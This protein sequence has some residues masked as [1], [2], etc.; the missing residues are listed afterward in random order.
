MGK[1]RPVAASFGFSAVA[2]LA[3]VVLTIGGSPAVGVVAHSSAYK[4]THVFATG[5]SNNWSGYDQG[6]L[7]GKGPFTS[8]S[9]TWVVPT[10]KYYAAGGGSSQSSASW[11]GLGGGCVETS[12]TITDPSSL[13]QAGTEQDVTSTGVASYYAWW[14]VVPVPQIE[15]TTVAIHPG[16]TVTVHIGYKVPEV[17]T[18]TLNDVTD[19]QSFSQAIPYPDSMLTAEWIEE[20]PV[21]VSAGGSSGIGALP[22]LGVVSFSGSADNGSGAGLTAAEG[23][24]LTNATSG[25]VEAT[26]SA[27]SSGGTAFKDCSYATSC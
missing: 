2:A 8:I 21:T 27:P 17:W 6:L 24:Q 5:Q 12:C 7:D 23:V 25:A 4:V 11:I 1:L 14:E 26:P 15:V 20:T 13:I 19:G 9:G 16:D 3:S 18:I 10:A 22:D